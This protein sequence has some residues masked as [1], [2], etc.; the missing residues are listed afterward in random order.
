LDPIL[1]SCAGLDIHKKSIVACVLRTKAKKEVRVFSTVTREVLEL[2]E[3][4]AER[5]VTHV[6][7]ESTGVF[8]KPIHDLLEDRFKLLL[9]NA[10]HIKQLPGRKTDVRD[11]EW[12]AQLLQHG[13]LRPSFVPPPPQREL[14]DLARHRVQVTAV[15]TQIANRIQKTLEG[16]NI[17]LS[18]VASD[19]LGVSGRD[20]IRAMIDG[21]EDPEKLA[22]LA[23]KRLRGKIPQLKVALEGRV[24]EHH[25][26]MLKLLLLD[27]EHQEAVIEALTS[28]IEEVIAR[29][30]ER[31]REEAP[32]SDALPF[33]EAVALL[34]TI[35]GIKDA[36]AHTILPEIGVDMSQFP[37]AAHLASWAG[38]SPGNN[39]SAGKRGSGRTT[40]GNRWLRRILVQVALAAAHTK[41]TYFGSQYR[42][43]A[44]KR[45][46][47]RASIAVAHTILVVIYHVL[48]TRKPYREL[49]ADYFDRLNP[50]RTA[51]NLVKRL[52]AL[53]HK[54][55][56]EPLHPAA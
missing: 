51:R 11:C 32:S 47:N 20:M 54:V 53:G 25:R 28:R 29:E 15:K 48:N 27:L 45:G 21:V 46:K 19:I 5:Q 13:L 40:K 30:D 42:R 49:G 22:E 17:K 44:A 26:F 36:A 2:G 55:T 43:L 24:T 1:E 35:P 41:G 12:I 31:L 34:K 16:A 14:R 50:E 33:Q 23:R 38:M 37:S 3:W 8:W 4:L 10:Q 6:A 39:Q 18:S 52:E 56:L 9:V 7:M